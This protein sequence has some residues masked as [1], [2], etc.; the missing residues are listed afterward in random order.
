[1]GE[2]MQLTSAEVSQNVYTNVAEVWHMFTSGVKN[3]QVQPI[4][5]GLQKKRLYSYESGRFTRLPSHPEYEAHLYAPFIRIANVVSRL[6]DTR[7]DGMTLRWRNTYNKVPDSYWSTTPKMRPDIVVELVPEH[8]PLC[9][10]SWN[11]VILVGEF[12]RALDPTQPIVQLACY[13]RQIF[14]E[15]PDRRFVLGFTLTGCLLTTWYFDRSGILGSVP[16]NVHEVCFPGSFV[17]LEI[18]ISLQKANSFVRFLIGCSQMSDERFG[19]DPT[20]LWF[21][22]IEKKIEEK[23]EKKIDICLPSYRIPPS[24]VRNGFADLHWIFSMPKKEGKGV[25]RF[26]T[27]RAHTFQPAEVITGKATAAWLVYTYEDFL[28][29]RDPRVS[30]ETKAKVNRFFSTRWSSLT[31]YPAEGL[32]LQIRVA[33]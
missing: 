15:Q 1:M 18:I 11:R 17:A 20:F 30:S 3:E 31:Y 33:S 9:K 26:V 27:F 7:Q 19:F 25:Q 24:V 8:E 10:P 2:R 23:I 14:M 32:L 29:Y 4:M 16:I 22:K 28:T 6:S 5:E 13:V 21:Q 12:K